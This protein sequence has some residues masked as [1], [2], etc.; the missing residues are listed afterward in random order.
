MNY[1]LMV[2]AFILAVAAAVGSATTLY[3]KMAPDNAIEQAAEM[4]IASQ[5]GI[6]VDLSPDAVVV[7]S[8]RAK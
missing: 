7:T 5:S 8:T 4:V 2:K 3:F 1:D 6:G